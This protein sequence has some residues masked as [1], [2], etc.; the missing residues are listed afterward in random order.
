M[1][2]ISTNRPEQ[3]RN[4]QQG[5]VLVVSLLFLLVLT[6]LGVSTM[7]SN[8]ME[9]RMSGNLRDRNLAFQAAEAALR[10]AENFIEGIVSVGAFDG[11]SGLYGT[12]ND[13]PDFFSAASWAENRSRGYTGT[14]IN[15]V[16]TQPRYII[17]FVNESSA[18][19]GD[20]GPIG[21]Y[22]DASTATIR[23][24]RITARGTGGSNNSVVILQNHYARQF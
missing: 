9:E 19:G 12:A 16:S 13:E 6:M 5:A 10:D 3:P 15:G 4:R 8:A 2:M 24:F 7:R 23:R 11:T 1:T 17:K 21:N 18:S 20:S 14:A 22:G